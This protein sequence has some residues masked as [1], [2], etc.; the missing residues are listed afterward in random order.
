MVGVNSSSFSFTLG[1][2]NARKV[3]QTVQKFVLKTFWMNEGRKKIIIKRFVIWIE[4]AKTT[5]TSKV[6]FRE[7]SSSKR[8]FIRHVIFLCFFS[9]LIYLFF[10]IEIEVLNKSS[11]ISSGNL[12]QPK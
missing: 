11:S 10:R 4:V 7:A 8:H 2:S 9:V 6:L 5:T 3:Q 1:I 12:M